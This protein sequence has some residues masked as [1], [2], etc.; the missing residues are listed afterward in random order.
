MKKFTLFSKSII[1]IGTLV[2]SVTNLKA[3][4]GTIKGTV[5]DDN[6]PLA[7]ASVSTEGKTGTTTDNSGTYELTV[8]PGRHTLSITYVGYQVS[9]KQVT[10]KFIAI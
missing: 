5:T 10:V 2:I 9:T 1:V 6:G 4:N 7:G 8:K 3:Q